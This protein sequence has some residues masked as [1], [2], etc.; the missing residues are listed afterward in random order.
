MFPTDVFV[1]FFSDQFSLPS[2]HLVSLSPNSSAK[3]GWIAA[4]QKALLLCL[5]QEKCTHGV[6]TMRANLEMG[7]Q[8]PSRGHGWWLRCRARRSTGWPVVLLTP[9]PGPPASPP[10]LGNYPHRYCTCFRTEHSLYVRKLL[11]CLHVPVD[12]SKTLPTEVLSDLT[13]CVVC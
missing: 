10:M 6:T 13:V 11:L 9:S 2:C 3:S 12:G 1:S 8:T 4:S 7:P 5:A